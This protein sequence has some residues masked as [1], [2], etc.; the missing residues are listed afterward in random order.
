MAAAIGLGR[1]QEDS[2]FLPQSRP[3]LDYDLG[4]PVFVHH[5]QITFSRFRLNFLMQTFAAQIDRL[6]CQPSP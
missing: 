4:E 3:M 2:A 5:R 1:S 6:I